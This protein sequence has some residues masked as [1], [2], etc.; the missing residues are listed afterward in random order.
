M[1]RAD[2]NWPAGAAAGAGSR[3]V[4]R[5]DGHHDDRED[6][7]PTMSPANRYRRVPTTSL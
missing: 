7:E 3:R 4:P 6:D 5:R 2:E 1:A